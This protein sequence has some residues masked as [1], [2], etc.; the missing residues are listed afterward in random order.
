M[1]DHLALH[2]WPRSTSYLLLCRKISATCCYASTAL[3]LVAMSER[4][5]STRCI[6]K[7]WGLI[8]SV[9]LQHPGCWMLC[10]KESWTAHMLL[11]GF[12]LY[13][14]TQCSKNASVTIWW[15]CV[16]ALVLDQCCQILAS[17]ELSDTQ[18][19][20]LQ[21]HFA[22]CS[23]LQIKCSYTL[24]YRYTCNYHQCILTISLH[25]IINQHHT[26]HEAWICHYSCHWCQQPMHT[27]CCPGLLTDICNKSYK[28]GTGACL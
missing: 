21:Q 24:G 28:R 2:F 12:S 6:V 27:S 7:P 17:S 1:D 13:D 20:Q 15:K 10:F 16:Q 11:S 4:L 19:L 3:L 18:L 25:H 23:G 26:T 8:C 5:Y 22:G 14:S 9:E